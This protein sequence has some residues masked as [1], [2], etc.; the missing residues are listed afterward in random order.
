VPWDRFPVFRY[1]N[2]PQ[3]ASNTSIVLRYGNNRPALLERSVGKG[4]VLTMTTPITE[5][6]RP[7]GWRAWNELAGPNDWPRFKLVNDIMT[8]LTQHDAGQY[9]FVAGQSVLLANPP[10]R[11][12]GRY[13]LF[14]PDG[15]TQPVQS[16]DGRLTINTTDSPGI[17]RLKGDRE[18]PVARGFSVNLPARASRLER[19]TKEHLDELFGKDRFQLARDHE[20]IERVQGQQ[21]TG[22]EFYP[23]LMAV[24]A[25][26]LILEQL[27]ANRFYR[28]TDKSTA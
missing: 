6:E 19:V 28:D 12:P 13:L 18:E 25:V 20:E 4:T 2:L 22:R 24:L 26:T 9:N 7:P 10:D 16:R 21:R 15:Q 11:T 3:L 23:L 8:Y 5:P 1:W 27:L 17:Y 14:M